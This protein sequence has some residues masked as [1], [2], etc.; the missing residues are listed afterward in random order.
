MIGT[1]AVT[2]TTWLAVTFITGPEPNEVLI[3]FY[4]RTRPS[5]GWGRSRG[6]RPT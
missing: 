5:A 1:V 6:Q 4:R 2:T 3:S